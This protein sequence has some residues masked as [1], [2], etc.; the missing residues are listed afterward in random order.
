MVT[1]H[2][3]LTQ[4]G[5]LQVQGGKPKMRRTLKSEDSL[6]MSATD[7]E[8]DSLLADSG[9]AKRKPGA[10]KGALPPHSREISLCMRRACR[11]AAHRRASHLALAVHFPVGKCGMSRWSASRA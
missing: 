7:S 2:R 8:A 9:A 6:S 11:G 3:F 4:L 5:C 1:R 10:K